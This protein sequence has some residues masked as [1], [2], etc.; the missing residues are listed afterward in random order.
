[1]SESAVLVFG[2]G[3]LGSAVAM[4][5]RASGHEVVACDPAL[6]ARVRWEAGGGRAIGPG[7]A[8]AAVR[9]SAVIVTCVSDEAA[10]D[11]LW[12]G[13]AMEDETGADVGTRSDTLRHLPELLT[14]LAPGALVIDHTTT[15]IGFARRMADACAGKRCLWLDAP[16]SGG[17]ARAR[18]GELV[19]MAGGGEE[20]VAAA[21][22]WLD[23]Y[24]SSV[25]HLGA[26]GAGQAGKLAN[27]LA[28][29]GTGLGLAA[30]VG[31]ARGHGLDIAALL[32]VLGGGSAG[33][34]QLAQHADKLAGVNPGDDPMRVF[35]WVAKDVQL[36]SREA[37]ELDGDVRS[38]IDQLAEAVHA[39]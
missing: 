30:A 32:A 23:A 5:L 11:A 35:G 2:L 13:A 29:A 15:G 22:P 18:T 12:F 34:D 19:A 25:V 31:F 38:A 33:S 28:I 1:V 14:A 7:E 36:A 9:R 8:S 4:R 26:A 17:V 6:E 3:E 24:C 16:L 39:R 10:L 20:A 37:G 27:Q 21:R